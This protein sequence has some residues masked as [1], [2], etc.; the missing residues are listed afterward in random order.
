MSKNQTE[1]KKKWKRI[2]RQSGGVLM[3]VRKR[4]LRTF[5]AIAIFVL[6]GM[7]FYGAAR[8]GQKQQAE[9][10]R[11]QAPTS[12]VASS[13]NRVISKNVVANADFENTENPVWY[14]LKNIQWGG[15]EIAEE[16]KADGSMNHFAKVSAKVAS[17]T[18]G[19]KVF[20]AVQEID[21]SQGLPEHWEFDMRVA[22]EKVLC[23]KQY[24]Q[25]VAIFW[26]PK[27][28]A[29]ANEN[30]E[31]N[32][33]LRCILHGVKEQ[34]YQMSN[35]KFHMNPSFEEREGWRRYALPLEKWFKEAYPGRD[36]SKG[37]IRL[38]MEA[39]YD[40][41]PHTATAGDV[42]LEADYDNSQFKWKEVK[43]E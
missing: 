42:A 27:D 38:L 21:L 30:P 4:F 29:S 40:T 9:N 32:V 22:K 18:M 39:R 16:K 5:I 43:S 6:I 2:E 20:G 8:Y 35:A 26:Q 41:M 10:A 11:N 15:Y 7:F 19:V 37:R 1:R 34:P 14:A 13:L 24:A 3:N 12:A 23:D 28:G 31:N 17:P 36:F 33:Q 25:A